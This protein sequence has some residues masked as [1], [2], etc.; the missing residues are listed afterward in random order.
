MNNEGVKGEERGSEGR[1]PLARTAL[2][3]LT[4]RTPFATRAKPS[5]RNISHFCILCSPSGCHWRYLEET[6]ARLCKAFPCHPSSGTTCSKSNR[7]TGTFPCPR[8]GL[9]CGPVSSRSQCS[10]HTSTHWKETIFWDG[11]RP[12]C[13]VYGAGAGCIGLSSGWVSSI[14]LG[15]PH[16]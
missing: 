5:S 8:P 10:S 3:F 4:Y 11:I 13:L 12:C 14:S 15:C 1:G 16:H 7:L 9:C 6:A 2:F